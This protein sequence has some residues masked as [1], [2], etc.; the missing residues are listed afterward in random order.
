M[1]RAAPSASPA[2]A[3]QHPYGVEDVERL[4]GLSR[5]T[6]R[7]LVASGFVEPARGP[8]NSL[9]FSFQDLITLRT[10]QALAD[11]RVPPRR[12]TRSLKELRRQLPDAMPLSGLRIGAEGDRVV[13]RQGRSRWQAESGQYLL[14]FEGDPSRGSLSVIEPAE[15]AG[16]GAAQEAFERALELE[17]TDRDGAIREYRGAVAIDP[18]LLDAYVNL[19]LLL[20]QAGRL[21]E[22]RGVYSKGL[23]ACGPDAVLLFNFGVVLEDLDRIGDA[24]QAYRDAVEADPAFADAHYNLALLARRAG[25]EQEAI[26]H[27]SDYRRLAKR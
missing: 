15:S 19:G 14:E 27:M 11:A 24:M 2:A 1:P 12:I 6:V 13:V 9:R 16:P 17:T 25:R 10:A 23:D 20:H 5:G 18:A 8:R 22:A 7:A 26:R 4:L 21:E 3:V